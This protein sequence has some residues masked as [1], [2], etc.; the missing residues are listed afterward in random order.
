MRD[1]LEI[2]ELLKQA[3]A[4]LRSLHEPWADTTSPAGRTVLTIFAGTA[5][6][7]RDLM[8]ERTGS[9]RVQAKARGVLFGRPP[10]LTG[11]QIKL[12]HRLIDEGTSVPEASRILKV[13]RTTL[14][15]TMEAEKP[16]NSPRA[17]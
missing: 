7:E 13:H 10:K 15:G 4:G 16:V 5:E 12:T 9:G 17:P 8:H 14:Y 11:E 2:A 6:F 1:L 3:E